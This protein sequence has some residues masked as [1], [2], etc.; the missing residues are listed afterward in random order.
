MICCPASASR[1]AAVDALSALGY[2]NNGTSRAPAPDCSPLAPV[3]G[4]RGPT[5]RPPAAQKEPAPTQVDI[6]GLMDPIGPAEFVAQ[7]RRKSQTEGHLSS[8]AKGMSAA[9]APSTQAGSSS[10]SAASDSEFSSTAPSDAEPEELNMLPAIQIARPATMTDAVWEKFAKRTCSLVQNS[11]AASTERTYTNLLR[12]ADTI[13]RPILGRSIVRGKTPNEMVVTISAIVQIR[14]VLHRGASGQ[15][16]RNTFCALLAALKTCIRRKGLP[17]AFEDVLHPQHQNL[18]DLIT[19]TKGAASGPEDRKFTPLRTHIEEFLAGAAKARDSIQ[20]LVSRQRPS[21][22]SDA[23]GRVAPSMPNLAQANQI[24]LAIFVII[25]FY[26]VRR[27]LEVLNLTHGDLLFDPTGVAVHIRTSK[28]DPYGKG[29]RAFIP[30]ERDLQQYVD[31]RS[32]H[33]FRQDEI[34]AISPRPNTCTLPYGPST[35]TY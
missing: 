13:L 9:P 17:S 2:I 15:F 19:G 18:M 10:D 33:E 11:N 5:T 26:A 27:A 8:K 34:Q 16:P 20:T 14:G 32:W 24:R 31:T 30:V 12:S 35:K 3:K 28:C 6:A 21:G 1:A 4:R 23:P 7:P 25:G 29:H 22:S